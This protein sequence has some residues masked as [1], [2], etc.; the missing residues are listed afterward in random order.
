MPESGSLI[1]FTENKNQW[2][3]VIL[4]RAQL[5]G[6]ALWMQKDAL[7]YSFYDKMAYRRNHMRSDDVPEEI[8][9]SGFDVKF[10]G[11]NPE[12][13]IKGSDPAKDYTNYFIGNNSSHWGTNARNFNRIQYTD[14]WKNINLEALG[15][16]NSLKYNFYVKPGGNP[17][18]IKLNYGRAE[19]VSLKNKS[20]V[21]QT[22]LNEIV[23]HP[24]YAYQIINGEKKDVPCEY[25]LK[26]NTL[27]FSFPDGY[28][29]E[30]ELIID[31]VLVFACSSGSLADN[32]G[33]TATYDEHGNLYSGGTAF[34]N[35]FPVVN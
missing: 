5:D 24:P 16:D 31:P 15:D 20:L 29:K 33:M 3:K 2:N 11:A 25:E 34:A 10:I 8:R 17:K 35:G 32:F 13:T 9:I 7:T 27:S 18:N 6:G 21:V 22:K 1:R 19:S 30:Y 28:N 12:V 4:Y 14:L 26:K 23:E